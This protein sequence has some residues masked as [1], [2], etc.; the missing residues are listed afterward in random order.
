MPDY[1]HVVDRR[2]DVS[3]Y[4][5][6]VYKW[7]KDNFGAVPSIQ[8]LLGVVEEVGELSH[9]ELKGLQGVRGTAEEHED[10]AKDAVGDIAIYLLNYCS[11]KGWD[12]MDILAR[13]AEGVLQ[14]DWKKYPFDGRTR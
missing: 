6:A 14:R 12:F 5:L 3:V 11:S 13:T 4:Q 8:N 10:A 7:Q 2:L 9:A 1:A